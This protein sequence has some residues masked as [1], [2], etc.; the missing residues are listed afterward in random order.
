MKRNLNLETGRRHTSTSLPPLRTTRT[1]ATHSLATRFRRRLGRAPLAL[2]AL[3]A[4]ALTVSVRE[5][6]ADG[7]PIVTTLDATGVSEYGATL[8]GTFDPNGDPMAIAWFEWSGGSTRP[9]AGSGYVS[10]QVGMAHGDPLFLGTTYYFSL[11]AANQWGTA[12]GGEKSFTVPGGPVPITQPATAVTATSATLNGSV[13]PLG[14][15]TSV[16]FCWGTTTAYGNQTSAANIGSGTGLVPFSAPLVGLTPNTTYHFC[17]MANNEI[18]MALGLDQSFT[19][20]WPALVSTLPATSV[21]TNSATLNSTVN[22]NGRPTTAWFQ[23]GATTNYGNLTSVTN[24]GSGTNA[25]PFSATLAGLTPGV[26]YHFRVAATNDNG[27]VY[28]SDQSFTTLGLPQISTLPATGVSANSATLNGTVNPTAWPTTAWFQWGATTNYGNL[29]SVTNLG[30]GIT[31]LPLSVPLAGLTLNVTYHF[32]IAATNDNGLAYGSDQSFTTLGPPQ[33][34][35]L[36]ARGVSTNSATLN[37]TVNPN[38]YPTTG[39]FQWGATTNYGNLTAVTALGSGNAVLPLSAPLAG[40]TP[41][42]TY[43]FRVAATNDSGLAYGSDQS[44][45][46][47]LYPFTDANWVSLGAGGE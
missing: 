28:G 16:W 2:L 40:L 43:H 23:W 42:V 38:G 3:L 26:A 47:A 31:A 14:S 10:T 39:W 30:S 44:F 35:T 5:A 22:P 45:T 33:V 19:T 18:H 6:S 46:T 24:L 34:S 37:G 1:A 13:Y 9:V 27:L 25:L 7:P 36:P 41:S 21:T 11:V 4:L 20:L 8:N 15:P 32:R 12:S 17:V 29:T